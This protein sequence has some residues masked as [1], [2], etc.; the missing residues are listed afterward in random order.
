M[1][2]T[3][4]GWT[5]LTFILLVGAGFCWKQAQGPPEVK[6][7]AS[8]EVQRGPIR[9][10]LEETGLVRAQVGAIVKIGARTT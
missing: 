5:V 7:L 10:V 2:K 4:K 3:K 1:S 8:V 6:I 9:K